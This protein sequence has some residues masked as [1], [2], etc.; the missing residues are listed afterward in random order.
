MKCQIDPPK[1]HSLVALL[2]LVVYSFPEFE[3]YRE[4]LESLTPY[5]VEYRYPGES[6]T[7]EDAQTCMEIVRKLRHEF[8]KVLDAQ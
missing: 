5:S 8:R 1:T 4:L 7:A 2:D 3:E 6:A